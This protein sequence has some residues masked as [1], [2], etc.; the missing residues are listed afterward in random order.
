MILVAGQDPSVLRF[1]LTILRLQGFTVI[2]ATD[3][4]QALEIFWQNSAE[5]TLMLID[6]ALPKLSGRE[7]STI[8]RH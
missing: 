8:S 2:V 1:M 3:G 4:R 7:S 5:L 6:I